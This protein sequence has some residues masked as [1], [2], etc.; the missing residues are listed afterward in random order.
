VWPWISAAL[1]VAVAL[2][3]IVPD[4]RLSRAVEQSVA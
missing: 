4:R 1:Y 3:W 2:T